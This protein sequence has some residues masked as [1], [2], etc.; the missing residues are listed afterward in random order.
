MTMVTSPLTG[1]F[2]F[3]D[4]G[5]GRIRRGRL[6]RSDTLQALTDADRELLIEWFGVRCILDLRSESETLAEGVAELPGA[7]Y[8]HVP[9]RAVQSGRS[10]RLEDIYVDHLA[11]DVN[12]PRAIETLSGL[13]PRPTVVHCASGKDRT[14]IVIAITLGLAGVPR[15]AIIRDYLRSADSMSRVIERF[16]DYNLPEHLFRCPE[17]AIT[18]L[19]DAIDR[20]FGGFAGWAT[21][22]GISN[23]AVLRLRRSLIITTPQG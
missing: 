7:R 13:L 23:A 2:N 4:T 11:N 3:R 1:A 9:L 8:A 15:E 16:R 10:S 20:D 17:S 18:A 14:G 12:L 5:G 22:A 6:Y 19:L 21:Y